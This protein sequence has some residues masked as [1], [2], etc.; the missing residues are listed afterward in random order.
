MLLSCMWYTKDDILRK[1]DL[2]P[3]DGIQLVGLTH[4]QPIEDSLDTQM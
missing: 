4:S 1:N 2:C 3:Y